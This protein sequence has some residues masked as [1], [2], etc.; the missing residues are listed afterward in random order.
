MNSE[1]FIE[2]DSVLFTSFTPDTFKSLIGIGDLILIGDDCFNCMDNSID[3]FKLTPEM[4]SRVVLSGTSDTTD[5]LFNR[6]K[7]SVKYI[8]VG[9]KEWTKS[10]EYLMM[11]FF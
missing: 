1:S 6:G 10:N 5:I 7:Y 4:S 8:L 2:N 3:E 9:Q 11:V